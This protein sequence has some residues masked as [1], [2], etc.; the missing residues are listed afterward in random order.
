MKLLIQIVVNIL[1]KLMIN[2]TQNLYN[3]IDFEYCKKC[4]ILFS[5]FHKHQISHIYNTLLITKYIYN[6]EIYDKI[7]IFDFYD[8]CIQLLISKKFKILNMSCTCNNKLICPKH[9][10]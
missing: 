10:I 1:K 9:T 8:E 6:N 3:D 4:N 7:A 2:L 5:F